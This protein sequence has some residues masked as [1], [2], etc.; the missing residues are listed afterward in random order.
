MA[1]I[2]VMLNVPNNDCANCVYGGHSSYEY[3]YQCYE[4]KDYCKLFG[5]IELKYNDGKL[6]RCV[7]CQSCEV[8]E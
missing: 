1:K 7:A 6:Q 2:K 4:E 5:N 3:A 8:D